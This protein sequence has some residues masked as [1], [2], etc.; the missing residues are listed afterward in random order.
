MSSS[1]LTY[2]YILNSVRYVDCGVFIIYKH[3]SVTR[4]VY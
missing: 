4:D 1:A 2:L 3:I